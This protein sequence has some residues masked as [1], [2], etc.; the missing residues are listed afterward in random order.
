MR[1]RYV[2]N[3][4]VMAVERI[5]LIALLFLHIGA[6]MAVADVVACFHVTDIFY[7]TYKQDTSP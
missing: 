2:K 7:P 6:A 3:L 5:R 4:L 1:G